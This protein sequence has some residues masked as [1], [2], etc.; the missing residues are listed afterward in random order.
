M[1]S[2]VQAVDV[3]EV[4]CWYVAYRRL[5]TSILYVQQGSVSWAQFQIVGQLATLPDPS[6][7]I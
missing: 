4:V 7:R 5:G 6:R 3:A 1:K 2:E